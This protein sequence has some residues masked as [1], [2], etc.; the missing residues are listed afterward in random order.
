MTDKFPL[1]KYLRPEWDYGEEKKPREFPRIK[2]Y[3]KNIR[4]LQE[5][6]FPGLELDPDKAY[7]GG[8]GW[9]FMTPS[10]H[11]KPP[12]PLLTEEII[13]DL[14]AN[15]KKLL[16]V[17]CG[18]AYLEILMVSKLGINLEQI[19][20]ADISDKYIPQGFRFVRFDMFGKW[21]ELGDSFD[22]IIFPSYP[23][24]E[25]SGEWSTEKIM[26]RMYCAFGSAIGVLNGHGRIRMNCAVGPDLRKKVK[27]RIESEF[28]NVKMRNSYSLST[29]KKGSV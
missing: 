13:Y 23:W 26:E 22:Y 29:I 8:N 10:Y 18:P 14:K 24:R 20:L 17:G 9:D 12:Y 1:G 19:T 5:E 11:F 15:G 4:S 27:N 16:D 6:V 2:K 7:V 21:P 25:Q 3:Y 28:P